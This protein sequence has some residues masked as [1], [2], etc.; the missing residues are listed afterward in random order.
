MEI[1]MLFTACALGDEISDGLL[2]VIKATYGGRRY[3]AHELARKATATCL[4]VSE[5]SWAFDLATKL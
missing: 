5:R 2:A 1:A 4:I 3:S